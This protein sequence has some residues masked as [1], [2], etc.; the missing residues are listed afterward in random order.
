MQK[1]LRQQ[2]PD[3]RVV[4]PDNGISN[5]NICCTGQYACTTKS[6]RKPLAAKRILLYHVTPCSWTAMHNMKFYVTPLWSVCLR[7]CLDGVSHQRTAGK[8]ASEYGH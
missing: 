5:P 8:N 4:L 3:E 2:P 6:K 1:H 7:H